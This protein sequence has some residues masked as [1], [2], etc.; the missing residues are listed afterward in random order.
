MSQ[1]KTLGTVTECIEI[2]DDSVSLLSDVNLSVL[3][4]SPLLIEEKCGEIAKS[5]EKDKGK[6]FH[7]K[8]SRLN[9]ASLFHGGSHR[10]YK[11]FVSVLFLMDYQDSS[12]SS[13]VDI[14]SSKGVDEMTQ[15]NKDSSLSSANAGSVPQLDS[16]ILQDSCSSSVGGQS[17][18]AN[19]EDEQ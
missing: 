18:F 5:D 15:I 8:P 16:R 17:Q 14:A 12:S 19:N 2:C 10:K 6:W 3:N 4:T 11:R 13:V 1:K 7:A 9:F